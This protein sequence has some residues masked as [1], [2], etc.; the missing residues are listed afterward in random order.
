MR[1]YKCF[2]IYRL[3]NRRK[4]RDWQYDTNRR[5][6]ILACLTPPERGLK[7]RNEE[8]NTKKHIRN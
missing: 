5:I 8:Y 1:Q 3:S 4:K 6:Y 2:V 7:C